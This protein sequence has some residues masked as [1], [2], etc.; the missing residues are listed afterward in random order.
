MLF[1]M[2]ASQKSQSNLRTLNAPKLRGPS[3]VQARSKGW[4]KLLVYLLTPSAKRLQI[5]RQTALTVLAE[6]L[7]ERYSAPPIAACA[8]RAHFFTR[9]AGC[10][11]THP[12]G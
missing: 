2:G 1:L 8:S 10:R 7:V 11:W 4:P 6:A 12:H 5:S 9:K 3:R